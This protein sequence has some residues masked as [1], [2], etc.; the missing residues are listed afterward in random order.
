MFRLFLAV[1]FA[2][3]SFAQNILPPQALMVVSA[4][5]R[6]VQL[7]WTAGDPNATGYTIE[8]KTLNGVYGTLQNVGTGTV[9]TDANFD[10]YTAYV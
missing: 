9:A 3:A 5:S 2:S 7:S 4:T 8:R 6:Q 10:P 1:F